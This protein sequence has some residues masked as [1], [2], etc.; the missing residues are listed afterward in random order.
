[1]GV[2]FTM[3][4]TLLLLQAIAYWMAILF[5]LWSHAWYWFKDPS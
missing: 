5:T 1:M 2:W 3:M 4:Q